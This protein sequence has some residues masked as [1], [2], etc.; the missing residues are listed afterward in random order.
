MQ[1]KF[2]WTAFLSTVDARWIIIVEL[3][4]YFI[5]PQTFINT[6]YVPGV[7]L[8]IQ[9]YKGKIYSRAEETER[10]PCMS[11]RAEASPYPPTWLTEVDSHNRMTKALL[12]KSIFSSLLNLRGLGSIAQE[13]SVGRIGLSHLIRKIVNMILD[14]VLT[15]K[16][17]SPMIRHWHQAT[18]WPS[19]R[20]APDICWVFII[21]QE[22][23]LRLYNQYLSQFL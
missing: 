6:S 16:S 5:L 8:F 1:R 4:T 14:S 17:S 19:G 11:P 20:K 23:Y 22:P 13:Y 3:D 7:R 15:L 18:L 2:M 21:C 10:W 9:K 12:L